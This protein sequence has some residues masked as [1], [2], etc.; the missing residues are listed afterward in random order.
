[1]TTPSDGLL[2]HLHTRLSHRLP[3]DD[4]GQG[5]FHP[6]ARAYGAP[7]DPPATVETL[8]ARSSVGFWRG[9]TGDAAG[10]A[11]AFDELLP[12]MVRVLGADHQR[13]LAVGD[14]LARWRDRAGLG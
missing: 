3:A 6:L 10:A 12:D 11:V 5:G 4:R 1:M 14:N 2:P 7:F 8:I 9:R 13:T